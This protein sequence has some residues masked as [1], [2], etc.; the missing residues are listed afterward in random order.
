MTKER[1]WHFSAGRE[2]Y[3]ECRE[4]TEGITLRVTPPLR[5]CDHGL[6]YSKRALDALCYGSGPIASTIEADGTILHD[7]NKSCAQIRPHVRVFDATSVLW[8]FSCWCAERALL[9]ERKAGREPDPRSWNAIRIRRRW[10][11]GQA[12]DE[13]LRA[14]DSA[15][16]SAA[17]RAADSAA[18]SAA[19][20]AAY[21]AAQSAAYSAAYGAA[22]QFGAAYPAAYGRLQAKLEAMLRKAMGKCRI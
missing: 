15:A 2:A 10:L 16:D 21:S 19:D 8:E 20:R 14:A 22:A 3:G 9:S 7:G 1:G 11:K 13:D 6:H 12:T 5:M 4:I 18:D 17:D